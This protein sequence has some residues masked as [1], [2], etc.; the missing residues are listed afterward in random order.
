[1]TDREKHKVDI[2]FVLSTFIT[3]RLFKTVILVD[4]S[5]S[6]LFGRLIA[7]F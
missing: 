3:L 5:I 4:P 2:E 7:F 1:M 6:S